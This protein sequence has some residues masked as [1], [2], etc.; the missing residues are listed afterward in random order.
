MNTLPKGMFAVGNKL[1]GICHY[2]DTTVRVN[3]PI[4]GGL[5]ICLTE[6]ERNQVDRQRTVTKSIQ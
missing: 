6:G 3:K 1:Y 4:F 2:C 5:H